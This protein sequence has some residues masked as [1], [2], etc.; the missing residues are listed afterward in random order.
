MD[1]NK[2]FFCP[3][4]LAFGIIQIRAALR[5]HLTSGRMAKINQTN[6]GRFWRG[7]REWGTVF[8]ATESKTGIATMKMSVE[9]PQ[10]AGNQLT[11]KPG[12]TVTPGHPKDST[13]FYRDTCSVMF[14]SVCSY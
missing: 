1:L 3:T 6:D 9:L 2:E 10:E 11:T 4:S 8:I 13:S 12:N 5:F 14:T 7:F